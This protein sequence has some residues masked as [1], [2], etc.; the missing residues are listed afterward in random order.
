MVMPCRDPELLF[1][2]TCFPVTL[3]ANTLKLFST[4]YLNVSFETSATHCNTAMAKYNNLIHV[5]VQYR[6][7]MIKLCVCVCVCMR[8]CVH[9]CVC[10]I[11]YEWHFKY[12]VDSTGCWY[13]GWWLCH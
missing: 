3:I 8:L 5:H 12:S 4:V 11:S 1:H 9:A 13:C 10:V 7:K 2:D 6:I